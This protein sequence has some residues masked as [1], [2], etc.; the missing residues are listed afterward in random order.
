MRIL[1]L[2]MV[3]CLAT[4]A[5]AA[6]VNMPSPTQL[7]PGWSTVVIPDSAGRG[8]VANKNWGGVLT[9]QFTQGDR[10]KTT[11]CWSTLSTTNY[12]GVALSRITALNISLYGIEGGE[13]WQ[14]PKFVFA[15]KKTPTD[16]SNRFAEWIPWSD[17]TPKPS[18]A[19]WQTLDALVDGSWTIPWVSKTYSTMADMLANYPGLTF[20]NDAEIQLAMSGFAG[21]SFNLG[22]AN[23]IGAT[24]PYNDD[25]RGVVDWFEVGVDG[26][27]T[28]Y[29]LNQVPEPGS[30]AAL[31]VGLVGLA[32]LRRRR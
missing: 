16:W 5:S 21:K 6:T 13:S 17:G 25:N 29:D 31:A 11:G 9:F 1:T 14:P 32:G 27:N 23:W 10:V 4:A 30:L 2:L 3:C 19:A 24:A 26:V 22:H 7:P 12:D 20:S 18:P 8:A 15:L 28:M